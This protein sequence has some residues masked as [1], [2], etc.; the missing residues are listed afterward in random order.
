[1]KLM[2]KSDICMKKSYSYLSNN[3]LRDDRNH[4]YKTELTVVLIMIYQL[5]KISNLSKILLFCFTCND[6]RISVFRNQL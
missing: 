2:C 6:G 3:I 1:M 4:L 5:K